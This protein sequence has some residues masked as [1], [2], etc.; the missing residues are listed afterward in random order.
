MPEIQVYAEVRNQNA[1][2]IGSSIEIQ[3]E[4][5]FGKDPIILWSF[6]PDQEGVSLH[7]ERENPSTGNFEADE[8]IDVRDKQ[9][10]TISLTAANFEK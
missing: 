2:E 7:V 5:E 3:T 8:S 10:Y 1:T 9:Q 4:Y 6:S